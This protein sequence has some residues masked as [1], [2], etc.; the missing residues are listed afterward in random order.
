[1]ALNK[2]GLHYYRDSQDDNR[3]HDHGP[4]SPDFM[5]MTPGSNLGLIWIL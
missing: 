2:R 5:Q 1:M 4:E 3:G